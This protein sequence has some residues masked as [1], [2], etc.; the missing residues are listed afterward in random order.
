MRITHDEMS[1]EPIEAAKRVYEFIGKDIPPEMTEFLISHTTVK[2]KGVFLLIVSCL[3]I[4]ARSIGI[5]N[6]LIRAVL[7]PKRMK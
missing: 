2:E 6:F 7:N 1:L 3:L 4:L 5:Q